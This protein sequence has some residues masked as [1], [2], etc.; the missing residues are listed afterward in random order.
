MDK[1]IYKSSDC[2]DMTKDDLISYLKTFKHYQQQYVHWSFDEITGGI[3]EFFN[4]ADYFEIKC[5]YEK[6]LENEST[7]HS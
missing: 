6:Y 5:F 1:A 4:P 3:E 2:S 7:L